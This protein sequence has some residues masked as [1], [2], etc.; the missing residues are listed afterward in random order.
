MEKINIKELKEKYK[1]DET[2]TSFQRK[3]RLIILKTMSKK[4]IREKSYDSYVEKYKKELEKLIQIGDFQILPEY[5]LTDIQIEVKNYVLGSKLHKY[6]LNNKMEINKFEEIVEYHK[7]LQ[8]EE[9]DVD[10]AISLYETIESLRKE[11]KQIIKIMEYG[12][13]NI[14][15]LEVIS[16]YNQTVIIDGNIGHIRKIERT[17]EELESNHTKALSIAEQ[18]GFLLG[19]VLYDYTIE[20]VNQVFRYYKKGNKKI[21]I[22]IKQK[23]KE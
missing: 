10:L 14:I 7:L 21:E 13:A 2:L 1:N 22:N 9:E 3:A 8:I 20:M 15:G 12:L 4:I 17:Y 11:E 16:H 5:N 6:L 23:V 18:Y 19:S